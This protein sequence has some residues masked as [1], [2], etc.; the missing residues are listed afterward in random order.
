MINK[1]VTIGCR[2]ANGYRR[3][4]DPYIKFGYKWQREYGFDAG[5]TPGLI[6]IRKLL[7]FIKVSAN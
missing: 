7:I 2:I 1:R 3:S 4:Q 5:D 6:R